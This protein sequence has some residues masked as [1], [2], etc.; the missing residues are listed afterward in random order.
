MKSEADTKKTTLGNITEYPLNWPSDQKGSTH[1]LVIDEKFIYVTGQNMHY[2]AKLDY[3]GNILAYFEMPQGS[4]PHG[5]LLDKEGK[6]WVSLEFH[7]QI[8]RLKD[9][10][11]I[12]KSVDVS[13]EIK[14]SE[15]KINPAPHGICLDADGKSIWFTG[16]RTSTIGKFSLEDFSIEHF[17][18]ENLA[19]LPIFLS[20]GS[21]TEVWGTELLGNAILNVNEKGKVKE[22]NI[23]T[24]NSRPIGIIPDPDL[25][26]ESMWFTQESGVKIGRIDKHG[27][28]SEYP[29]PKLQ[30][31]DILGSLTFDKE[32]NLWVQV[33]NPSAECY[34]YLLKLDKSIREIIGFS[35]TEVPFTTHVLSSRKP[36]LHRIKMDYDGNLWFTEMMTDKIGVIRF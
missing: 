24:G 1:E 7:G 34:S 15:K 19:S 28:I 17:Q 10:G 12:D 20:A 2:V 27:K 16:K 3:D 23:P 33:Y 22:F 4:G 36:M 21:N 35:L 13:M 8:V 30:E 6:V 31:N 29:V 5:I 14:G 11:A 18:L 26:S 25:E 32:K 9:D